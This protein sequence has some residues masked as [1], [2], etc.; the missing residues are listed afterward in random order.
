[1]VERSTTGHG[2][3]L[4][5]A[6]AND[7]SVP[8]RPERVAVL[9][10]TAA[11]REVVA[12]GWDAADPGFEGRPRTDVTASPWVATDQG[13]VGWMG[14]ARHRGDVVVK[15]DG[16]LLT[17]WADLTGVILWPGERFA[18]DPLW[19]GSDT[20]AAAFAAGWAADAPGSL[21]PLPADVATVVPSGGPVPSG[22]AALALD[23]ADLPRLLDAGNG[24][25]GVVVDPWPADHD[26][27]RPEVAAHLE[28]VGGWLAACGATWVMVRGAGAT[29]APLLRWGDAGTTAVAALHDALAA[30]RRGLGDAPVLHLGGG[31][32]AVG[33]GLCDVVDTGPGWPS[34]DPAAGPRTR[35]AADGVVWHACSGPLAPGAP[36]DVQVACRLHVPPA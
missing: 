12:P 24:P 22:G 18:L 27:T 31:P 23:H 2:V 9:V 6:V 30:L 26:L 10:E 13:C 11:V 15:A 19:V 33:A 8:A 34:A 28:A 17:A 36:L 35:R 5:V 25:A 4:R 16:W 29:L 20:D 14:A 1:V 7:S 3:V 32:P 21:R